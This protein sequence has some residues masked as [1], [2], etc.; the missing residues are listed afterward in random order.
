MK[1][2]SSAASGTGPQHGRGQLLTWHQEHTEVSMETDAGTRGA[3]PSVMGANTTRGIAEKNF[4]GE[5]ATKQLRSGNHHS[6]R[7]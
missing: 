3:L 2:A 7:N 5:N 6:R 1:S 4:S